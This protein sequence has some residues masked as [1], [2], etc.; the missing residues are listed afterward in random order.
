MQQIFIEPCG[1]H[2]DTEMS[3]TWFWV[4]QETHNLVWDNFPMVG[5]ILGVL[6]KYRGGY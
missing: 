5:G 1:R 6:W 3:S 2:G 4:F